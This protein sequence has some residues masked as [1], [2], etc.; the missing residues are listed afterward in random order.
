MCGHIRKQPPLGSSGGCGGLC[1]VV[2]GLDGE[3]NN[4]QGENEPEE[5]SFFPHDAIPCK[6]TNFSAFPVP[7]CARI[8]ISFAVPEPLHNPQSEQSV[9]FV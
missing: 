3:V 6:A 2:R 1:G 5:L 8:Q 7:P 9:P 4:H